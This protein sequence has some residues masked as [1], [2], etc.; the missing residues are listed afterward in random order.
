VSPHTRYADK[1]TR[2]SLLVVEDS[3]DDFEALER[4]CG[5]VEGSPR[6]WRFSMAEDCLRTLE[7]AL[8]DDPASLP[9]MILLDLNLPGMDGRELLKELKAHDHLRSIPVVVLTTSTNPDDVDL[10]YRHHANAYQVKASGFT[11]I[12][13]QVEVMVDYWFEH[14]MPSRVSGETLA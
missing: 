2:A 12:K 13:Q 1:P 10:C 9:S 7:A 3:D 14:V 5:A 11:A 4:A 6:L 8:V